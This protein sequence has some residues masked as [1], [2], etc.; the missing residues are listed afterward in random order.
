M[1]GIAQKAP[2]T[3]DELRKVR[4]VEDR[5]ARGALGEELL[6]AVRA[7]QDAPVPVQAT[8]TRGEVPR[9]LRAAVGLLSAWVA[10]L[11][12]DLELDATLL[13]TRTDLEDFLR[14]DP[15][16]RLALGWR[17]ELVGDQIR[18]LLSG[19]AALAFDGRGGLLIERRSR[20]AL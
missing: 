9:E 6:A 5:H 3:A 15:Q 12:R 20:Q 7:G 18:Q 19:G 11:A 14:D 8:N 4:G 13:A 17:A 10:Q 16:A 1:A 2:S